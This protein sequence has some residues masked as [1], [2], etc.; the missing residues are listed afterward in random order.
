ML[1]NFGKSQLQLKLHDNT[2]FKFYGFANRSRTNRNLSPPTVLAS[3]SALM[4]TILVIYTTRVT[5]ICQVKY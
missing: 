1:C 4:Q 3:D 2:P 5:F